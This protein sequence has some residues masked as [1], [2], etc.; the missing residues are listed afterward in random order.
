ME[1]YYNSYITN[2][3]FIHEL[4]ERY[5]NAKLPKVKI[6]DMT[7][8]NQKISS[9]SIISN[10]LFQQ[11]QKR[12][13]NNEQVLILH[14]RRGF[15]AIK[16]YQDSD[17]I[18]HCKDCDVILTYHATIEKLICHHCNK[19]YSIEKYNKADIKYLGYGT[20]HIESILNQHFPNAN[21]M[22]MDADSASTM[23]K[24]KEILSKFK[25]NDFNILL[26]T[27]MIAKGLDF[28][29][30]TL[31][32]VLNADLGMFIPDF[33]SNEKAFQ[34]L[35]QVIGRSGRSQKLG[36]AI[37][38]TYQPKNQLI[39][40]ST[41]Y[42]SKQFYNLSLDSRKALNYPPFK[43]LIRILFQ[44]KSLKNCINSSNKIYE[45]LKSKFPNSIIGPLPCPIE[46]LASNNRYHILIKI[47]S[48]TISQSL[49]VMQH[50]QDNKEQFLDKNVKL[51]IDIDSISVL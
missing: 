9:Q 4:N 6:I 29:N 3:Y 24:Q 33:R 51:L 13:H 40:M 10:Y 26:G 11:I 44:S 20:E 32:A 30:I 35:Y 8:D 50:I 12:I 31:V 38:Q 47:D 27:Q 28:K 23:K 22:R 34:L 39:Q 42:Q 5:G 49:N 14:N 41:N 19:K 21:I 18:L 48:K 37:I 25:A 15:S 36:E 7:D 1:T 46:K 45:I 17:E 2:K 43:R 16:V